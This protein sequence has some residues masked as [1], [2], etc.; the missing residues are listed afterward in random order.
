MSLIRQ[1]ATLLE[2]VGRSHAMAFDRDI[3]A[4]VQPQNCAD[5]VREIGVAQA[6]A[7]EADDDAYDDLT[8][9]LYELRKALE[10]QVRVNTGVSWEQLRGALL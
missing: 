5:L 2:H 9:R 3:I 8:D 6:L 7:A 10:A 4:I 1:Q